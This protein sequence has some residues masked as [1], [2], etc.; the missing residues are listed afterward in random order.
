MLVRCERRYHNSV[1]VTRGPLVFS[2]RVGEEFRRLKGEPPRAD[3][4]V[5][6]TTPW[7]FGLALDA[8]S[9][10]ELFSVVEAPVSDVPFARDAAPVRLTA[11]GRR[12]PQWVLEHNSAG[13][14]PKSPVATAEP[15]ERIELIPYG[16]TNLRISEFP[17]VTRS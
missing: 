7:N 17:E 4:E 9:V 8:K 2:L 12:V 16:S 15:V 10:S 5:Y 1:A 14:L 13:P 11:K 3:W 6:P